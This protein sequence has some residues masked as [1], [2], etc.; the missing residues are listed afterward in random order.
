MQSIITIE[1]SFGRSY[2]SNEICLNLI[3][4]KYY[5]KPVVKRIVVC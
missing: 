4:K 3:D 5:F 1:Y 2:L